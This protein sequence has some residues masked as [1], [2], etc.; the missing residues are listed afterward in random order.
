VLRQAIQQKVEGKDIT[1][2]TLKPRAEVHDLMEALRRSL[3]ERARKK[4]VAPGRPEAP[5][6]KRLAREEPVASKRVKRARGA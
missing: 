2:P 6:R 4:P 1:T 3:D 5:A